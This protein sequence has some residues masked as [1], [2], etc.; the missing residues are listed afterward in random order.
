MNN[1]TL[2]IFGLIPIMLS[3]LTGFM[4]GLTGSES[5]GSWWLVIGIGMIIFIPWGLMRLYKIP[6]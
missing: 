4:E 1:K 2:A 5:D 3:F 6:G